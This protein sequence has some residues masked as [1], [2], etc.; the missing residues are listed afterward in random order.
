[1]TF[2]DAAVIGLVALYRKQF[3][4][5]CFDEEFA[6]VRGRNVSGFYL[7]LLCM[8]AVTVVSFGQV[9][10]LILVIALVTLPAA[11]ARRYARSVAG[12]MIGAC[13]L[14][15]LFSVVGLAVSFDANLPS[16]ATI[17][18]IAGFAYFASLLAKFVQRYASR[19]LASRSN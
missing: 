5:V 9:V 12:M 3:L 13:V 10:G 14:E 4:A 16:G 8:V 6:R 1:M 18:L 2:L 15:D 7:L 11:T 17:I 19:T